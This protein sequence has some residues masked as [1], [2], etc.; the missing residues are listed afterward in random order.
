MNEEKRYQ[1]A[2]GLIP[3]VGDHL[4]KQ[5]VSYC[6]SAA[7]VFSA[8]T[9][10]L[11]KIPGVGDKRINELNLDRQLAA[12]D[13]IIH[14]CLRQG[15]QILF[16]TDKD[17]PSRLKAIADSPS[18]IYYKGNGDLNTARTV[19]I[20][21]TRK[22]T[23]YGRTVVDQ[24]CADLSSAG[25]ATIS[26][27]A[28]GI[29]IH[30]HRSSLRYGLPTFGV[31]AGGLDHIYPAVHKPTCEQ[32]MEHGGI[33]SE[34]PLGTKPEAHLFPARNRIIAGLSDALIV[35]EAAEKGGALITADIAYTYNKDLFA[36]PGNITN[37]YSKGCHD[38]ITSQRAIPYTKI[39]DLLY[40]MNWDLDNPRQPAVN[41]QPE[42]FP[43]P[44]RTIIA[45]LLPEKDGLQVD[46]LAWKTQ[47]PLNKLAT[48]LLALEFDGL[49]KVLPGKRYKIN[50]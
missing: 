9:A 29:D 46:Q 17:Y 31:L 40:N 21:G 23:E 28:Y 10:Q 11:Q 41:I 16:Y 27:L 18:L 36:V 45:A 26:G 30:A 6:G 47:V 25:V 32:M 49:V 33:L 7:A 24:L 12:A 1:V 13:R 44:E 34:N 14:D 3:G 2:L 42:D 43:E 38:L 35:I 37:T 15:I 39:K 50:S 5:L 19:G 20:V 8:S 22:A 48:K 4:T